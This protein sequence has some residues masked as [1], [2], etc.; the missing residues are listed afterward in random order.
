MRKNTDLCCLKIVLIRLFGRE[1]GGMTG[2]WGKGIMGI[3]VTVSFRKGSSYQEECEKSLHKPSDSYFF[4][5]TI[6]YCSD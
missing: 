5:K 4:K 2:E 6:F 1:R 3:F